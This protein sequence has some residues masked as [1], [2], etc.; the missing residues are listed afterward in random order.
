[1]TTYFVALALAL[2]VSL[3]ATPVVIATAR[4]YGWLDVPTD[5]RKVHRAP[6]PRLG[7]VAVVLAFATPLLGLAVYSNGVSE[8]LYADS[9]KV[10]AFLAGGVIIVGLGVYDDLKG[11]NAKLKLAVQSVAAF[12]VW[13]A[14]IR[15]ELLGVPLGGE[16]ELA[17][18][19]FPLTWL[20]IVGV[21]NALN[22]ID[23]LDGLAAGVGLIASTVLFT[24]ALADH[25]V[26]MCLVMACLAGALLGF[27]YFNFNPAKI[28]LGDSGSMFLGFVLSAVSIW[29]YRKGATAAALLIPMLALGLPLLDTTLAFV[30]RVLRKTNPFDADREHVHHRL[31][32]LGL[33]HRNAVF[34]L[35]TASGVFALGSLALLQD[36]ATIGVIAT[37]CI[38]VAMFIFFRRVGVLRLPTLAAATVANQTRQQVRQASRSIRNAETEDEVWSA[39]E[40][41]LSE[42]RAVEASLSWRGCED[43]REAVKEYVYRWT[44]SDRSSRRRLEKELPLHEDGVDYGTL[45][46]SFDGKAP[47]PTATL[48]SEIIREALVDF[49]LAKRTSDLPDS[50]VVPLAQP[51]R[52]FEA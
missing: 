49:A 5:A 41:I 52:R 31:L 35:Y 28:F 2:L 45:T 42:L 7:G 13:W 9:A 38:A 37:L 36:D 27:L 8:I 32:D 24:V 50:V 48:F 39:L 10:L 21:T 12:V 26:L 47:E 14:G 1:M 19:S 22:L 16:L 33:S 30:R 6:V 4:R 15:I 18:L 17:W 43:G 29:T 23:G 20:W 46:V 51:R 11:A 34:T 3:I 40:V 44:A 25:A